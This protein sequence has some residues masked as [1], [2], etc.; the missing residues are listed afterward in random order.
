MLV[1][2]TQIPGNLP[3]ETAMI[4][5]EARSGAFPTSAISAAMPT[6]RVDDAPQHAAA[7][8]CLW[9]VHC[10]LQ[11]AEKMPRQAIDISR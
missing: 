1:I 10:G 4:C 7:R 5:H 3:P 9:Q 2:K 8:A 11:N 6:S